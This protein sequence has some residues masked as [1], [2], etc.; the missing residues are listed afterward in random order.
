MSCTELLRTQA[1]LDGEI[2]EDAR[3]EAERHAK[4]CPECRAFIVDSNAV[5]A[6]VRDHAIRWQAPSGLRARIGAAMT[7][8]RDSRS[9]ANQYRSFLYGAASGTGVSAM[10]AAIA[11][12]LLLPASPAGVLDSVVNAHTNALMMHRTIEVASSNHHTVKPWFAGHIDISPPVADFSGEGF[13][14]AGGRV[15]RVAGIP[16]AVVV[17][18][19]GAHEIDLFVWADRNATLPREAVRHG[20]RAMFWKSGDLDF[21]AVSDMERGELE[22]FTRLVRREA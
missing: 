9:R 22:K 5:S 12:F 21:A 17:Y 18:H 1:W 8:E 2:P 20:Y 6:A 14:L 10:A 15:D 13:A 11:F 7:R 19:H 16:A 4:G 3:T